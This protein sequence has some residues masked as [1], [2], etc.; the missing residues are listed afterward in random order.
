MYEDKYVQ[1]TNYVQAGQILT[2]DF[3]FEIFVPATDFD[4]ESYSQKSSSTGSD[5]AR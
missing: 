3:D 2:F 5:R 4:E 1:I